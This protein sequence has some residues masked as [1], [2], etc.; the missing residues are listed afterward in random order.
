MEWKYCISSI[1]GHILPTPLKLEYILKRDGFFFKKKKKAL[2]YV[3][4]SQL[5]LAFRASMLQGMCSV[6]R[7]KYQGTPEISS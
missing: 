6:M 5:S 2:N 3:K 1:L 4:V 7:V